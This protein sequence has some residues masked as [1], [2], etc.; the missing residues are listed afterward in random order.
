MKCKHAKLFLPRLPKLTLQASFFGFENLMLSSDYA[1]LLYHVFANLD[2][3]DGMKQENIKI[4]FDDGML[5]N[6][7]WVWAQFN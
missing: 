3:S 5:T 7:S 1:V 6:N 2:T 4:G